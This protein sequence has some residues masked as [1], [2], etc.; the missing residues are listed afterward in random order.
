MINL[1]STVDKRFHGYLDT[2]L[3]YRP[4]RVV[5][6]KETKHLIIQEREVSYRFYPH[7]HP[8]VGQLVQRL[9]QK[10]TSGLQAA[11]T[12]CKRNDD[13]TL[14]PFGTQ[15]TLPD[16]TL[17]TL[18][19]GTLVTPPSGTQATSLDGS[20]SITLTD[21]QQLYLLG[22]TLYIIVRGPD[23]A[24]TIPDGTRLALT[25]STQVTR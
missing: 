21:G 24:V 3:V 4:G 25:N 5:E 2:E 18:S 11:D 17:V 1:T 23:V 6:T 20:T 22:G 13:G 19:D 9:L 10:S 8:Y 12:E 15:A 7:F 14:V 16:G